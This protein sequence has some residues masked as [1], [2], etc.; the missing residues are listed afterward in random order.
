MARHL[1]GQGRQ[2]ANIDA[3][4]HVG[5]QLAGKIEPINVVRPARELL[6]IDQGNGVQSGKT[7]RTGL[8]SVLVTAPAPL[9]DQLRHIPPERRARPALSQLRA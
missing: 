2:V 9:R 4:Q 8:T 5:W 7:A 3:I 6:M 1:A